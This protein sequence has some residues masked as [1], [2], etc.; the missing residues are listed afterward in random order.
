MKPDGET[1]VRIVKADTL[2]E[3]QR[4][5]V[6]ARECLKRWAARYAKT[7]HAQKHVVQTNL[8]ME[9]IDL[10]VLRL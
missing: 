9:Q 7:T 3:A 2:E 1:V 6:D 10:W 5:M 4:I 8:I